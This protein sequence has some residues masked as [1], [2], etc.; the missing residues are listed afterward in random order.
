MNDPPSDG[1]EN[2]IDI[3]IVS[4]A[5]TAALLLKEHLEQ[6]DYRVTVFADGAQLIETLHAEKPNLLICDST[7][8]EQMGFEVCSQIKADDELFVIPVLILTAASTMEDLLMVLECNA[9]NFI[10]PPYNLPDHLLLIEGM[11]TTPVERLT[12]DQIK[13]QFRVSHDD[14][15][16]V[17]AANRRKLLEY[18]LSSFEIAVSKSKELSHVSSE[19]QKLSEFAKELERSVTAQAQAIETVTATV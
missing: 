15:T 13:K 11:L 12:P 19:L 9:D 10:A 3:F 16:Y 1:N 18:L 14:Q 4:T 6:R 2:V 7:T 5:E 8:G 17:V